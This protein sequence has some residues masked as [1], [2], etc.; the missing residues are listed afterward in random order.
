MNSSH[1]ADKAPFASLPRETRFS[2]RS[3]AFLTA[4]RYL[5][6]NNFAKIFILSGMI[7]ILCAC[8]GQNAQPAAKCPGAKGYTRRMMDGNGFK[9]VVF[10]PEAQA[11]G[12]SLHVYIQ[13]DGK[14]F[15]SSR[16]P[17]PD[18]DGDICPV[19]KL[20]ALDPAPKA[21]MGRPC[22]NGLAHSR[23][24]GTYYWTLGRYSPQIVS[25]LVLCLKKIAIDYRE[26]T[27]VG[28]SGGGTLAVLVAE[29]VDKVNRIITMGANLDVNTWAHKH[30]YTPMTASM[31][32][33]RAKGPSPDVRQ[34]HLAGGKDDNVPWTIIH[35]YCLRHQ[36]AEMVM[37]PE[38]SHTGPWE[39]AF[40]KALADKNDAKGKIILNKI[41]K[42]MVPKID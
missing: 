21:L 8:A 20:M 35:S 36:N 17:S 37:V 25:S 9:H 26:I 13:G 22:Y 3:S 31:D 1:A 32:P 15:I 30:R 16:H 2:A 23:N 41:P 39:Q 11:R 24:C 7:T 5:S 6:T 18:P 38:A 27:L 42:K 28:I 29:Y 14:P 19:F 40:V 4:W 33:M 12:K 10:A 34:T